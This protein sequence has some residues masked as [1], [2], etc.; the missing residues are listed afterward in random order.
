MTHNRLKARLVAMRPHASWVREFSLVIA[1]FPGLGIRLDTYEMVN[2]LEVIV[3]EPIFDVTCL[4]GPERGREFTDE[5][6]TKLG[7]EI[8]PYP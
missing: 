5:W 2:V 8:A 1:P 3:G 7:F 4:V 6:L